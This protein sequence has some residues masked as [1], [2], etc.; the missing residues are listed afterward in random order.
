MSNATSWSSLTDLVQLITSTSTGQSGGQSHTLP[1]NETVISSLNQRYKSELPFI[2]CGYSNLIA[3]N[4][5]RPLGSSSDAN[6]QLYVEQ[7]SGGG[8]EEEEE[9]DDDE[10]DGNKQSSNK[11]DKLPAHPY[12]LACRVHLAMQRTGKSQAIVFR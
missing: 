5:L 3:I 7:I 4:P 1:S 2:Y 10:E 12:G 6:A 8:G 11:G 9:D